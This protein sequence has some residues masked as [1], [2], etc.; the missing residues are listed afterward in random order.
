[1]EPSLPFVLALIAAFSA[2]LVWRVLGVLLA[3]RIDP[4]GPLMRWFAC[5]A[6]AMLAALVAGYFVLP[7]GALG[8]TPIA[9]RLAALAAA[10]AAYFLLGRRIALGVALGIAVFLAFEAA[11]GRF[12]L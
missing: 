11:S 5:V 3:T 1:M 9:T 7:G 10:F 8:A 2:S 4:Q 6:Y 12:M